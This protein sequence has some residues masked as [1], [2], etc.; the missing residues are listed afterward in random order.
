[1]RTLLLAGVMVGAL[2][3]ARPREADAGLHFSFSQPGFRIF[4]AVPFGPPTYHSPPPPFAPPVV[5]YRGSP[6][7]R[8]WHHRYPRH[9][10]GHSG[11]ARGRHWR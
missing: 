1:M 3:L 9:G 7:H 5:I 8:H 10:C 6:R 4:V 2:A 11:G